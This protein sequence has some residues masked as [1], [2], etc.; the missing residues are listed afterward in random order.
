M[1]ILRRTVDTARLFLA[2]NASPIRQPG[3][4]SVDFR[5]G[6]PLR[7]SLIS[8]LR[9]PAVEVCQ[10]EGQAFKFVS[11]RI[12][13]VSIPAIGLPSI[14]ENR[15]FVSTA[16]TLDI[17]LS[18]PSRTICKWVNRWSVPILEAAAQ[19]PMPECEAIDTALAVQGVEDLTIWFGLLTATPQIVS[20]FG[21]LRKPSSV[22]KNK[23][24]SD[25]VQQT[26]EF[27]EDGE[28]KCRHGLKKAWCSIC[29][30]E[31]SPKTPTPGSPG[32]DILEL[33]WPL[34]QP[35]PGE[36]LNSRLWFPEGR[37][38]FS[39]Q[40]TGIKFL[41][42]HPLALLGDEMGLVLLC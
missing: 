41:A 11:A 33:I 19:I 34:L 32:I 13:Q 1:G 5:P 23:N 36:S 17:G 31:A 22:G 40:L 16:P 27:G 29:R 21:A 26:F 7:L 42:E 14:S 35:P 10:F 12:D 18:F 2:A 39:F 28:S 30:K 20:L 3:C 4:K 9:C 25:T 37:T 15:C 24:E 6:E 38:P 8:E